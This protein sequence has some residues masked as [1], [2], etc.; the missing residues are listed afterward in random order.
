M[1]GFL[2]LVLLLL[3]ISPVFAQTQGNPDILKRLIID[4]CEGIDEF[5]NC[6]T[7]EEIKS[8]PDRITGTI[9]KVGNA[10]AVGLG[11]P[12]STE[13]VIILIVVIIVVAIVIFVL[14]RASK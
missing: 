7:N 4:D 9:T 12:N 14:A 3:L 5:G 13:I 10:A 11:I 8:V 1:K 6:I 2:I